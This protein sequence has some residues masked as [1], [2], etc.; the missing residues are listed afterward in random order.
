MRRRVTAR[1]GRPGQEALFANTFQIHALWTQSVTLLPR[2]SL[3]SRLTPKE[4]NAWMMS[5]CA[6][7]AAGAPVPPRPVF[8]TAR[9]N[10]V[11]PDLF[12][13]V[14]SLPALRRHRTAAAH[15]VRTARCNG[16]GAILVLGVKIGAC[17][18]KTADGLHLPVSMPRRM[19]DKAVGC[20]MKGAAPSMIVCGVWIGS[21]C[22]QDLNNLETITRCRQMQCRI[23]D[24]NPME[25]L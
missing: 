7:I 18:E 2:P 4:R 11:D 20:V 1:I 17:V 12:S 23:A 9:W 14:G 3:R 24:V 22:Q 19:R 21:T 15:R 16:V 25:D 8:C 10:G 13:A 6:S 5:C